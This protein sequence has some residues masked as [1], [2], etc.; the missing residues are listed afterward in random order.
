MRTLEARSHAH[1]RRQQQEAEAIAKRLREASRAK[2]QSTNGARDNVAVTLAASSNPA[3]AVR[4]MQQRMVTGA[5]RVKTAAEAFTWIRQLTAGM[6][7]ASESEV[8]SHVIAE[9]QQLAALA[10][11]LKE[12]EALLKEEKVT[13]T[14]P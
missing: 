7:D 2:Q 12:Q 1:A 3:A 13:T 6:E 10:E 4:M 9:E 8:A 14:R 11:Q 5:S